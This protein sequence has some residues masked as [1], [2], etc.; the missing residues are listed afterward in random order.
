MPYYFFSGVLLA[1][2]SPAIGLWPII[3]VAFIPLL[4]GLETEFAGGR[5]TVRRAFLKGYVPGL[6]Y[7]AAMFFWIVH[8]SAWALLPILLGLAWMHGLMATGVYLGLK[9]GLKESVLCVW[10]ACVWV[11]I[12]VLGSDVFFSLPSY[13]IGYLVWEFPVFVQLADITG[14]FGVSFWIISVNILLARWWRYG[15]RRNRVWSVATMIMTVVVVGYGYANTH[16]ESDTSAS[17]PPVAINLMHS[18]IK[19]EEKVDLSRKHELIESF[20]LMTRASIDSQPEPPKLFI[21]PETSV[22]VWLRSINE[23]E[24]VERLLRVASDAQ[25]S[26]LIGALSFS[27]GNKTEPNIFNSAFLV[28]PRG[29]IAQE[30]RKMLLAPLVEMTPFYD[31]LPDGLKRRWPSRLQAGKEFGLMNLDSKSTFG[32]FI[33]WEA[34]FPD[35]VRQLAQ[36]GTGFLVNLT[37]DE[38]AFGNIMSAYPIPLPHVVYRAVENRQFVVRSANWG[39]SM[40]VSPQGEVLQ[41]SPVGT[42][43]VLIGNVV[44]SY[45]QTF[46]TRHGFIIAKSLVFVTMAWLVI[47]LGRMAYALLNRQGNPPATPERPPKFDR[48]GSPSGH[49]NL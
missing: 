40:F 1:L 41:S 21:W 5:L 36:Q 2:S 34:F 8:V 16:S 38:A 27:T 12:E 32:V 20:E 37:N 45:Q 26:I 39:P 14:V 23:K 28:P 24:V 17:N 48:S 35:S 42:A 10:L 15:I 44:P 43:G 49:S 9:A 46:F 22:P 19:A 4:I 47:L 11:S 3:F 33:C 25:S 18:A 7:V 13:A 6:I 30:Y 31:L 29:Y